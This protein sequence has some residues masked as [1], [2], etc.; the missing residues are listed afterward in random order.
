LRIVRFEDPDAS[1]TESNH[2]LIS[3]RLPDPAQLA[4]IEYCIR[5]RLWRQSLISLGGNGHHTAYGIPH[6][7]WT[8][9]PT[10]LSVSWRICT[11]S[12]LPRNISPLLF[13]PARPW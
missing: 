1:A 5:W 11:C 3:D 12:S 10:F 4:A 2:A 8:Q 9:P 6:T 7:I 13:E